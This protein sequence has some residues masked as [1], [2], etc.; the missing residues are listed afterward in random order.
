MSESEE[1][2]HQSRAMRVGVSE[3]PASS[4]GWPS[5]TPATK[6]FGRKAAVATVHPAPGDPA[7]ESTAPADSAPRDANELHARAADP[8]A[9]SRTRT[10]L[11]GFFSSSFRII[12]QSSVL[13]SD[14]H[15]Y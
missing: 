8:S 15:F 3:G 1:R 4:E 9:A 5:G 14:S 13:P 2:A 11:L 10:Y 12:S 6:N 7:A